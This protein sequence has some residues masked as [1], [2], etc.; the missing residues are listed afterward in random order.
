MEASLAQRLAFG[1]R[2]ETIP[3]RRQF[4]RQQQQ[5]DALNPEIANREILISGDIERPTRPGGPGGGGGNNNAQNANRGNNNNA[6]AP[7]GPIAYSGLVMAQGDLT[8]GYGV[9]LIENKMY[10]QVNQDGKPYQIATTTPNLPAKFS[11][12]AALQKDGTIRLM[13]DNKEIGKGKAPGLFKKE[14]EVPLRVGNEPRRGNERIADYP[15]SNFIM[16]ANLTNAKLETLE[17]IAPP[18]NLGKPDKVISLGV[19]KDIMKYDKQLLTA[20]AGTVLQIVMRNPDHM[21]HN[22]VLIKPKTT[23]KVGAAA[24]KLAQGAT[25]GSVTSR[26]QYVPRMP[27]VL[28]ATPMLNPGGTYRLTIKV[29]DTPGDY[30]YICTF[31]GHWRIM[32]G[33]LRVTK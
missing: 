24:D 26:M 27:E 25:A 6:A 8:N 21:Q 22:F 32:R 5:Q 14:F 31:P 11:F 17:G 20:K 19:I 18:V 10:F 33:I 1:D 7:Q 9:Y 12:K 29:P 28:Y 2:I 16:R 23:D 30:P 3:L 15:D 4:G 13:V